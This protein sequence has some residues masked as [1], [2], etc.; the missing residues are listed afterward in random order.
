MEH[1]SKYTLPPHRIKLSDIRGTQVPHFLRKSLC[2][3]DGISTYSVSDRLLCAE[4]FYCCLRRFFLKGKTRQEKCERSV[5]KRR[6]TATAHCARKHTNRVFTCS[7]CLPL[8]VA[9]A[10]ITWCSC[11]FFTGAAF[12][13]LLAK[14]CGTTRGDWPT[15]EYMC[16]EEYTYILLPHHRSLS[17]HKKIY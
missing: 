7:G 17:V 14:E 1:T 10:V 12:S 3:F 16:T 4:L 5:S 15:A 13:A 2:Y 11:R 9:V 6:P 8:A